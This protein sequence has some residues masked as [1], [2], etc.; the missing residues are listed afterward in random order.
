[1][2]ESFL[3][4]NVFFNFKIDFCVI[5]VSGCVQRKYFDL[6]FFTINLILFANPLFLFEIP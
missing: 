2:T 6:G 5:F 3:I 1:M 4:F